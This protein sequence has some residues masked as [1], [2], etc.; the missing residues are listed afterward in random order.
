MG[1]LNYQ[2]EHHLFPSM[3][4]PNLAGPSRWSVQHCAEPGVPYTETGLL[5]SYAI[6][7][8]YLNHV[9]LRARAT[10]SSA[11]S[12]RTCVADGLDLCAADRSRPPGG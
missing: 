6:V 1:G 3:P 8:A 12:A 2:I 9:G 4:R 11:R 7:V 10:R 5:A